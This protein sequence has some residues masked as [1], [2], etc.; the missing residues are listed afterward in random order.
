M[1]MIFEYSGSA[2]SPASNSSIWH[3]AVSQATVH[4]VRRLVDIEFHAFEDE[5][6]NQQLSYRDYTKPEHFERTVNI[7]T[8]ALIGAEHRDSLAK[9]T[10]RPR[11]NSKLDS[12]EQDS[13]TSFLRVA[14][15]ESGETLSFIKWE[16]KRYIPEELLQSP[17]IGY[18]HEPRMNKDWFVLNEQIRRDYMGQTMHCYVGMLATEPCHQCNGA[19][20]LL[21]N[22]MLA[23]ADDA[24]LMVYLEATDTAKPMYEKHGFVSITEL[25][26]DP[27]SYGIC[28]L[29]LER[30]T[31]MV[32]GALGKC[33]ERSKVKTWE[34]TVAQAK[35]EI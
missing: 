25:R 29:G 34:A 3:L 30:Q 22:A 1:P 24:G 2:G 17:G 23:E 32:R 11:T 13:K 20:I 9:A 21:L 15:T 31:V 16:V 5:R 10:V 26:F 6:T 28:G 4:D 14:N 18:A 35:A 12:A 19:G 33:G 8:K 7:Y 27:A